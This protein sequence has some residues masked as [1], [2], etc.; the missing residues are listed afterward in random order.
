MGGDKIGFIGLGN[1][2]YPMAETLLRKGFEVWVHSCEGTGASSSPL[3]VH[4]P[5]GFP[6]DL[7]GN[8]LPA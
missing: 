3:R 1:I 4:V 8:S 2:G 7:Q 5:A 6:R